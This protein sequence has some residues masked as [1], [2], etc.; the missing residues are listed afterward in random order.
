MKRRKPVTKSS[1]SFDLM[2]S[3]DSDSAV[4]QCS[5]TDSLE[6]AVSQRG[7]NAEANAEPTRSQR[8]ANAELSA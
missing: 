4:L 8:G 6:S 1:S 7:A 3:S 2:T 5:Q